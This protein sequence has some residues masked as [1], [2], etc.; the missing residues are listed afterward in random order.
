MPGLPSLFVLVA[1]MLV[2]VV[3]LAA[4]P[5]DAFILAIVRDDGVMLPVATQDRGR[6]RMPWPGPAK[7]AE[8]PVTVADCPLA[9]W[10]LLHAPREWTLHVPGESP[11]ALTPESTTWVQSYCRQQ[12]V[13]HS[14]AAT[15]PLL[16]MADGGRAPKY[17][18]AAAGPARVVF[19]R[20]VAADSA[21]GRTLLDALQVTFNREERLMFALDYQTVLRNAEERERV[22]VE[23]LAI[24]QGPG[25]DGPAYFVELMRSYPR[26]KPER[27]RWCDQVTYMSGWVRRRGDDTLDITAITRAVTS[28]LLDTT[29]RATP[30]AIVETSRGPAWLIELYRPDAEVLGVFMAPGGDDPE[31]M[32]IRE[33]GRCEGDVPARLLPG[34]GL[35]DASVP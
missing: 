33:V 4:A 14:R 19:P 22:A 16:R 21:E 28:C 6:W 23:A 31:P 12:V 32:L 8:V 29:Q 13:L 15:R 30:L 9:W 34:G 10:G 11:R 1:S 27:L 26:D 25:R 35:P 17:G 18:V 2:P 24:H 7:E 20:S 3:L 5:S